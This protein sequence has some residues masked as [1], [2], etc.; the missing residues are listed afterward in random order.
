MDIRDFNLIWEDFAIF[1]TLIYSNITLKDYSQ[2][3]YLD[4]LV[5]FLYAWDLYK[6]EKGIPLVGS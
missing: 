2:Q 3:T 4:R 6:K 1:Y 5:D